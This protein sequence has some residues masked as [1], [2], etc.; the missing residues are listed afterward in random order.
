M[1]LVPKINAHKS[2]LCIH[3]ICFQNTLQCPASIRSFTAIYKLDAVSRYQPRLS[4]L[5]LMSS[6][7]HTT[8]NQVCQMNEFT[9]VCRKL[10]CHWSIISSGAHL[11]CDTTLKYEIL[12]ILQAC[13]NLQDY[14][15]YRGI[16]SLVSFVAV[17]FW[18]CACYDGIYT[19]VQPLA[20]LKY[21]AGN[22]AE[23]SKKPE[24]E[25][26]AML[27]K[28]HVHFSYWTVAKH[29]PQYVQSIE[30]ERQN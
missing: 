19:S 12:S 17:H 18:E 8:R 27:R 4:R 10:K 5:D 29:F 14:F 20:N 1:T 9:G 23:I 11:L 15:A 22:V 13:T 25:N 28:C 6:N 16:Y 24:T 21:S 7:S 26:I 3:Q 2:R 30:T